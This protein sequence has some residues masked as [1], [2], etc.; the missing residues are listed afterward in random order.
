MAKIPYI[1]K[2]FKS[3]SRDTINAA[4]RV[5]DEYMEQGYVLTLRQ[6]YYQLV[7]RG[8]IPN[9][10]KAYNRL[11]RLISHARL[12]G[13][14]DWEAIEDRTRSL[15]ARAHWRSPKAVLL[16]AE[17]SFALDAWRSQPVAPE[18]WVEKE[19]LA[20]VVS[21]SANRLDVP[22]FC[23]RGYV[24]TS[25]VWRAVMRFAEHCKNGREPL[26]IYLG[27]HDPS[28]LDMVRDLYDRMNDMLYVH[29]AQMDILPIALT[30]DQ[31]QQYNPPPNP[32]KMTDSRYRGYVRE[33]GIKECWELDALEP[34]V[35]DDL[36]T[37]AI[38]QQ[39]DKALFDADLAE[40]D[41]QRAMLRKVI[42]E[43]DLP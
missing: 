2:K 34:Q 9:E 7:A 43:A 15:T 3:R 14:V 27:D 30:L 4:T 1:L 26:V 22:V 10:Q 13:L 33:L 28:G 42:E 21:R 41:A 40:E 25:E 35:M 37:N 32:V 16:A 24:S 38:Y 5:I 20:N 12:A 17:N 31:I 6:L 18:V 39:M 19:A 36:I 29:G 8:I 23:C 11:G